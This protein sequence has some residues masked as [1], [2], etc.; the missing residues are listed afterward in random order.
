L[1]LGQAAVDRLD[2]HETVEGV[3]TLLLGVALVAVGP[4]AR[5]APPRSSA[6]GSRASAILAGL[7]N[8][9]PAAAF[10]M[11][12]LLGFGGPKRLV[13]TFVAMATISE[14]SLGDAED[15]TLVLVYIAVSTVLV[16]VPVGIV[17]IAGEHAAA[18]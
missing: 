2:S 4:R 17:I 3:L 13:L 8:V 18:I 15:L 7:R 6:R 12:G 5:P 14:A 16:S 10:S 1:V 11:A 9:R